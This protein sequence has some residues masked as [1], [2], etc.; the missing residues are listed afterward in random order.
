MRTDEDVS[1]PGWG[2]VGAL[3]AITTELKAMIELDT[4]TY[5]LITQTSSPQTAQNAL[6]TTLR[7]DS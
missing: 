1:G 6:T 7:L 3:T 2:R 5:S 4:H